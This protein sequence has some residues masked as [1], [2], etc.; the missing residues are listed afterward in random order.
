MLDS[1]E[2]K[3]SSIT[4][5]MY[6]IIPKT[7]RALCFPRSQDVAYEKALLFGWVKRVSRRVASLAQIG[8]FACRLPKTS[9]RD[10]GKLVSEDGILGTWL[11]WSEFQEW[12]HN[13]FIYQIGAINSH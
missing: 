9:Q 6:C 12:T 7:P 13:T 10:Q 3:V 8:E 11:D 1:Y 5:C 4:R 2:G